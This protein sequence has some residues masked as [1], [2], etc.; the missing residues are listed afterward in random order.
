MWKTIRRLETLNAARFS[1]GKLQI[2]CII[3]GTRFTL[4]TP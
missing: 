3:V 2:R 4:V 1:A